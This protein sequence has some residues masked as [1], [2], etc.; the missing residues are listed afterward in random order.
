MLDFPPDEPDSHTHTTLLCDKHLQM[1]TQAGLQSVRGNVQSP[2]K[3]Q[4]QVENHKQCIV[5][6]CII[7]L[8]HKYTQIQHIWW[9]RWQ[10]QTHLWHGHTQGQCA[11]NQASRRSCQ[12]IKLKLS[13][14]VSAQFTP[15]W[16]LF[17]LRVHVSC[18]VESFCCEKVLTLCQSGRWNTLGGRGRLNPCA[19]CH[20]TPKEEEKVLS[21]RVC[22]CLPPLSL[23]FSLSPLLCFF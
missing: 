4:D 14:T 16:R 5:M 7:L 19:L 13:H 12:S 22:F 21:R 18:S 2:L 9:M 20:H 11:T 23:T 6:W 15:V 10:M 17:I 1:F 3:Y 8:Q